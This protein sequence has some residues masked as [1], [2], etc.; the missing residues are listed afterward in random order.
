MPKGMRINEQRKEEIIMK[1]TFSILLALALILTAAASLAEGTPFSFRSGVTFGMSMNDV[2]AAETVR[3]DEIDRDRTH[4]PVEFIELEYEHITENGVRADLKCFFAGDALAAIRVS[5]ETRDISFRQV[6]ADLTAKYG[7]AVPVD[8]NLLGNGIYAV[9]DD[10]R[11]ERN[12]EAILF[13]NVMIILEQDGDDIDVT[14]VDLN[15]SYI[16]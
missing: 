11:L 12:A 9:D 13:G 10:G 3:Y 5:Y 4:G 1:K 15:A 2:I 6:E 8:L 7:A 14:F 16:K